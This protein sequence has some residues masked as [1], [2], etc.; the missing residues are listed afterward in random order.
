MQKIEVLDN[1]SVSVRQLCK[2][3]RQGLC[4][5]VIV[6]VRKVKTEKINVVEDKVGMLESSMKAAFSISSAAAKINCV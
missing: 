6:Y 3:A 5:V 1:L 4:Q 2:L